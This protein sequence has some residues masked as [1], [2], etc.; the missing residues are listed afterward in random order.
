MDSLNQVCEAVLDYISQNVSSTIFSV[1]FRDLK[2]EELTNEKAVFS[3]SNDFKRGILEERYSDTIKKSLTEIIGFPLDIHI[4]TVAPTEEESFPVKVKKVNIGEKEREEKSPYEPVYEQDDDEEL[5]IAQAIES[6]MIIEEYTFDNFIVGETNK[7]AHAA[8][9]AVATFSAEDY[10]PLFIWGPSGLGKTHLL[11]AV[12][13]AIKKNNPNVKIIY[14]KGEEFTNELVFA[15]ANGTTPAFRERYRSADVLLIDDVQFIAGR[16]STQEEFFHT[17]STLYEANKQ[18]ILTSDRP[19][20]EMRTLEERIRTRFEWGL[21]ADIQPPSFE[22]RT[23]IIMKKA[24]SLNLNLTPDIVNLL[25]EKLQNNVRQIEGAL[26]KI[27]AISILTATP[28][29]LDMCKRTISDFLSGPISVNDT[30]NKILKSVSEKY[31]VPIDEIKGQKRNEAIANARH[32]SI[33]VIRTLTDLPLTQIGQIFGRNYATV[34][35]SIK[36]VESDIKEKRDTEYEIEEI[37]NEV[38]S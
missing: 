17:F 23:A 26:K 4:I 33:Y 1:W 16:E 14:K 12:T 34:I 30:V 10:N 38:K 22:L 13:N 27:G 31:S 3:I 35:S 32:I 25:A 7:L 37:I 11:Y 15:I 28:I 18:I 36:K 29:T 8:C 20:K 19:P 5:D 24:E 2:L 21:M 9:M 6:N